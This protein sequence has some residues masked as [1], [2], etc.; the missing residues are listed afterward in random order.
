[1]TRPRGAAAARFA[2]RRLLAGAF[3]VVGLTV[4]VHAITPWTNG[5]DVT[6]VGEGTEEELRAIREAL[7]LTTNP[8]LRSAR[9]TCDLITFGRCSNVPSRENIDAFWRAAER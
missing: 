8:L 7:G 2:V 3:L 5:E 4:A 1:V 6:L 9:F